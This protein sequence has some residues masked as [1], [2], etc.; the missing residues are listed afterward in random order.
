MSPAGKPAVAGGNSLIWVILAAGSA[1]GEA[2]LCLRKE[3]EETVIICKLRLLLKLTAQVDADFFPA[4]TWF[5]KSRLRE[6]LPTL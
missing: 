3:S 2:L 1:N 6:I 5:F 4:P